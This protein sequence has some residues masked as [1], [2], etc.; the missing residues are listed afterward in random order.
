MKMPAGGSTLILIEYISGFMIEF[1]VI[2]LV[3]RSPGAQG[4]YSTQGT[5]R[6]MHPLWLQ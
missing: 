5:L 2:M 4:I 3:C 1:S 6:F